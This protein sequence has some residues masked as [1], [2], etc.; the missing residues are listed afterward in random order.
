MSQNQLTT[1]T[2]DGPAASGKTTVGYQLAEELGYVFLD[3][4]VMYRGVT[5]ATLRQGVDPNDEAGVT[6]VALEM[7]FEVE[8]EKDHADGRHYTVLVDGVDSTWEIRSPAVNQN[9]SVVSSYAGVRTEMVRMQREFAKGHAVVMVG[10]DIGTV[11]L[12][13]AP[14][15]F[16][17]DASAEIRAKRRMLDSL[18]PEV[19]QAEFAKIL[20]DIKRRDE[21]DSGREHSPLRPADDAIVIDTGLYTPDGVLEQMRAAIRLNKVS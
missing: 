2:I 12:P 15:K 16:Y 6:Q 5:L 19:A 17:L 4:G 1:I 3:T 7:A 14:L 18:S 8:P 21:I 9:V 20:A 11:V 13:D 10:R